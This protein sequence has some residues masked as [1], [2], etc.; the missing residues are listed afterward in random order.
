MRSRFSAYV[1]N[2]PAYIQQTYAQEKQAE[3]SVK[4]IADFANSCRFIKLTVIN[5]EQQETQAWVEF[6]ADY[7]YQN[8]FCKLKERS[9]FELRDDTWYYV[10]GIITPTT[11][12]KVGRNDECPC[13][14]EKKYKKCHAN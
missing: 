14:S 13:G 12:I 6:E 7:F 1:V 10:D 11:D 4:E 5:T 3:N 8:L 2:N 9:Y